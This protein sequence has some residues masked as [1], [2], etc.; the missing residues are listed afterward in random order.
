MSTAQELIDEFNTR[1]SARSQWETYWR[2]IARYVLPQTEEFESFLTSSVGSVV[3]AVVDTPV[4]HK[5]SRD[6]YDMTSLWGVERL[7]AGLLS[8]KTPETEHWHNLGPETLFG[9]EPTHE[10]RVSLE[11]LR[12]YQFRVRANPLSG[13]WTA[14]KAAMRSMSGFGDGYMFLE[15]NPGGGSRVPFTYQYMGLNEAFPGVDARGV[16]N[17][18]FRQIRLT[19]LQARGKFREATPPRVLKDADDPAR[20][21]TSHV[22]L[23]AVMPREDTLRTRFGTRGSAFA[24]F[25]VYPADMLLMAEGG[26]YSFPFIRYAWNDSGARPYSEGPVAFAIAE[27]KS[28]Q[29]MA[30]NE[31]IASQHAV[32]PAYAIGQ[33][34]MQRLNLNPGAVNPGLIA[35][36]GKP[37]FAPMNTGV[38]P[39]FATAVMEARRNNL[40]E[41]LYLNLWQAILPDTADTATEALIRA[42]E[43]GDLLG[44]VGL[45]LNRGL[46]AAV[47][48]EIDILGRR[49]A[50]DSGSPLELP[51][52]LADRSVQPTWTS[53]LDRLRRMGELVGLTR[54]IEIL[55]SMAQFKPGIMA[56]L[57]TDEIAD[58]TQEIL[59]A[60][61]RS[62]VSREKAAEANGQQDQMQQTLSALAALKGGGD[63]A[64]SVGAGVQQ[65][66]AGAETLKGS[67]ALKSMASAIPQISNRVADAV[68]GVQ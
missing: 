23:H 4:A 2:E 49:G 43:K 38:R 28:M 22:F 3:S 30:K 7:T 67:P 48:R 12:N 1:L 31:L 56:R 14:H 53:P 5:R 52:S 46:Q 9:G 47:D 41:L 29:E 60:P 44:P 18:M 62:L 16:L 64:A 59:G 57:D 11:R 68:G 51:D 63:A 17:S 33:K 27:I 34:N 21:H 10:E 66:A 6:I 20:R 24:S 50:F 19:A 13:F 54:L 58:I 15:D 42:Q 36:D 25:Y 65:L 39:D 40:R 35:P 26:F 37:L 45:S 32:R 61:V 8:L 55:S